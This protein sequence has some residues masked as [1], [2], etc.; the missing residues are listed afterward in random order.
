[1][2]ASPFNTVRSAAR[3]FNHP[4]D[5]DRFLTLFTKENVLA[6][7]GRSGIFTMIYR[8]LMDGVPTHVQM[9]A[10]MV[11]EKERSE[12]HTSELQSHSRISYAVFCLK[13][14]TCATE[15]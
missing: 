5:L 1:M 7:I 2:L 14:K 8:L 13:K 15:F 6:E 4:D 12:E 9:N 10:A 3:Q 11:E